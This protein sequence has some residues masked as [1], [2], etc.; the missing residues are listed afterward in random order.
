MRVPWRLRALAGIGLARCQATPAIECTRMKISNHLAA[1]LLT[2]SLATSAAAATLHQTFMNDFAS[3]AIYLWSDDPGNM[4]FAGTSFGAHLQ[5]WSVQSASPAA[6]V[7]N[8]PT[9]AAGQGRFTVRFDHVKR[10]FTLQWAEVFFDSGISHVLGA[11]TL[12]Y[13]VSGWT[14]TNAFSHLA[15][16]P[17]LTPQSA[18]PLPQSAVLLLS[19]LIVLPLRRLHVLRACA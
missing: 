3:N 1:L 19:A 8:G 2:L 12:G 13:S 6:L 11:G 9:V 14:G 10:P 7:L 15:D 17:H 16:I 5:G 18:V 4:Q